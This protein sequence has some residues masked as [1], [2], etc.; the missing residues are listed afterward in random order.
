MSTKILCT[1]NP[2]VPGIAKHIK[3]FFPEAT[4]ISRT[5]GYDLLSLEGREKFKNIIKNYNVFINHS[6]L[7]PDGQVELL[8]IV[9]NSWNAGHV[10]SIGSVLEFDK[11]SWIDKES[12]EEKRRLKELSLNL[13]N[14]SFKTSYIIIGGLKSTDKDNMRLDPQD[15]AKSI[16]WILENQ[17]HIPLMYIDNISDQLTN[18]WL[19]KKPQS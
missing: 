6:Q 19:K 3:E 7:I 1:G 5:N 16:K 17:I 11:W 13:N 8:K 12:A 9:N 4:F 18:E 15:V 10:I 14:E 2:Y